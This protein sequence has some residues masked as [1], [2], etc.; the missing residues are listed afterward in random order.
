MSLI[1]LQKRY[2]RDKTSLRGP[3]LRHMT[4]AQALSYFSAVNL[5]ANEAKERHL[6]TRSRFTDWARPA[7]EIREYIRICEKRSEDLQ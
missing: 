7:R 4:V 6:F 2:L 5:L 1:D 3:F